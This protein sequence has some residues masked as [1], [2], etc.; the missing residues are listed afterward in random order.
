MKSKPGLKSTEA[1]A[2][3]LAD[4]AFARKQPLEQLLDGAAVPPE[5]NARRTLAGAFF[6]KIEH[7][8]PDPDQPR[9]TIDDAALIELTES[10]R[11]HGVLQPITVRHLPEQGV[12]QVIAGERRFLAA[13]AAGLTEIPCWQQTPSDREVLVHQVVENWQRADLHPFDLADTL[14]QLRDGLG[15]SQKDIARLTSKPESDISKILSLLKLRP[16]I[17][18]QFRHDKTGIVSRRHLEAI[19]KLPGD[20]QEA[21]H[22]QVTRMN[23]TAVET[24]QLVHQ[25][26]DEERGQRRRRGAPVG[27]KLRFVTNKATV[28]V[29]FRRKHVGIDEVL[30]ALDEAKCQ[31]KA[32]GI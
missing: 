25:N 12:Y 6:I 28:S 26:L 17:Q 5:W 8:Q 9:K 11:M 7:I 20:Q 1:A 16:S 21:M 23:L 30:A 29:V 2:S 3:Q 19:A 4:R 27:T 13:K 15:F 32:E 18:A 24:E 31:V 10:I 14:A 22:H